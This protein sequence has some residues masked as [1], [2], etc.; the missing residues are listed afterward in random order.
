MNYGNAIHRLVA[1]YFIEKPN[2]DTIY[3]VN[4]INGDKRNNTVANLEWISHQ[5]NVT[6]AI[7]NNLSDPQTAPAILTRE[8]VVEICELL[9]NRKTN[10]LYLKDIAKR[11]NVSTDTISCIKRGKTWSNISEDYINRFQ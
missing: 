11:Y 3:E 7:S 8:Q 1:D 9:V 6:H 4:H 5:D 2:S 10:G